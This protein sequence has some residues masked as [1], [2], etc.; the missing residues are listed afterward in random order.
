[1]MDLRGKGPEIRKVAGLLL[2]LRFP[3]QMAIGRALLWA[4]DRISRE[5][6]PKRDRGRTVTRLVGGV[7]VVAGLTLPLLVQGR[8]P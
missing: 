8:R 4:L 7:M 5:P 6:E 2:A 1:M 3:R